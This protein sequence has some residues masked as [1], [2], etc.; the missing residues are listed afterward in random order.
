[1]PK[2]GISAQLRSSSCALRHRKRASFPS[3][4]PLIIEDRVTLDEVK[5]ALARGRH[6]VLVTPPAPEQA[7]EFWELLAPPPPD[8]ESGAATSAARAAPAALIICSD[9]VSAAEWVVAAP[10]LAVVQ[11]DA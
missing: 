4:R 5:A 11:C 9:D 6:V 2:R 3:P 7:G 1:I 10:D 8:A